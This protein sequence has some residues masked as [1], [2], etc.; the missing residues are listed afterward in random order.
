MVSSSA[1]NGQCRQTTEF[2]RSERAS[3]PV[4]LVLDHRNHIMR[5]RE[6][7]LGRTDGRTEA[8]APKPRVY[9]KS[10][11]SHLRRSPLTP[12][13]DRPPQRE[14]E[15]EGEETVFRWG[16]YVTQGA[17]ERASFTPLQA[18][19]FSLSRSLLHPRRPPH[20]L[21]RRNCP[22]EIHYTAEREDGMHGRPRLS[23]E[24]VGRGRT[25]GRQP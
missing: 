22:C 13:L 20:S 6:W 5:S 1:T 24:T 14:L 4:N 9:L 11:A 19:L 3:K 10:E 25:R 18:L 17:S 15:P 8:A 16:Q 23:G 7:K 12:S 21:P 2:R